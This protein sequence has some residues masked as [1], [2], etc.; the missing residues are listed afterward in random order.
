MYDCT[1]IIPTHNRHRYLSRVLDYYSTADFNLIVLDSTSNSFKH[2][3][4]LGS[5]IEYHHCKD[6]TYISKMIFGLNKIETKYC[7]IVADDDFIAPNGIKYCLRFLNENPDYGSAEG[8]YVGFK[9]LETGEVKLQNIYEWARSCDYNGANA[10]QRAKQ[11]FKPYTPF[12]YAVHKTK[13]LVDNFTSFN[14]SKMQNYYL[15]ELFTVLFLIMRGKHKVL[16]VFYSAR[17]LMESVSYQMVPA[18]DVFK[19]K[20]YVDESNVFTETLSKEYALFDKI[21]I[22]EAENGIKEAIKM[23]CDFATRGGSNKKWL[24]FY[25]NLWI[26]KKIKLYKNVLVFKIR[27]YLKLENKITHAVEN[28]TGYEVHEDWLIIKNIIKRYKIVED[29]LK[30]KSVLAG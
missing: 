11:I 23:Y 12:Y 1:I 21:D 5:H 15:M 30:N 2:K 17:E 20:K 29:S 13:N 19:L 26:Y 7:L 8:C 9:Y 6:M 4:Q 18:Y 27:N 28:N 10:L 25:R 3:D 16:P 14:E 24:N 22:H